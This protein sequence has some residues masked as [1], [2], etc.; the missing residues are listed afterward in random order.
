M[1]IAKGEGDVGASLCRKVSRS[2]LTHKDS[3]NNRDPKI[4]KRPQ[5]P[6]PS[7]SWHAR[8][9]RYKKKGPCRNCRGQI[10]KHPLSLLLGVGEPG[11]LLCY[12]KRLVLIFSLST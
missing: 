6:C 5:S 8:N 1:G 7:P 2:K 10:T 3:Q 12:R 11:G 9:Q 4:Q